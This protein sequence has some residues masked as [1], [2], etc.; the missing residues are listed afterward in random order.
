MCENRIENICEK[1][2]LYLT[3]N[4]GIKRK[5]TCDRHYTSLKIVGIK[6]I[7][8]KSTWGWEDICKSVYESPHDNN[9]Q[10]KTALST[11]YMPDIV[12]N[13]FKHI[14]LNL[15]SIPRERDFYPHI[16]NV[17]TKP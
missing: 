11:G 10:V 13:Q 15:C 14:S 16:I 5:Y 7:R 6:D 9:F 12:T 1:P 3:V 4:Q 8:T 2:V 17:E